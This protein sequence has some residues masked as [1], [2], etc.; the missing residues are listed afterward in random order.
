MHPIRC[1]DAT[2]PMIGTTNNSHIGV[3]GDKDVRSLLYDA[4]QRITALEDEIGRIRN[5]IGAD[6][7]TANGSFPHYVTS[8]QCGY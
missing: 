6:A 8:L 2:V 5:A 7:M 1:E 3:I 4:M